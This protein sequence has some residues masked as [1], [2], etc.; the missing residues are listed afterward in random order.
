M[1]RLARLEYIEQTKKDKEYNDLV[2]AE[3]AEARY[4]KHYEI[5]YDVASAIIDFACK[6]A[7]YRELTNNLIPPTLWRHW[8]NPLIAGLP[9]YNKAEPAAIEDPK[10]RNLRE[11]EKAFASD[12]GFMT[13][14]QKQLL[15][16]CD[17]NE[18]KDLMGEWEMPE[19]IVVSKEKKEIGQSDN[20]VVG[21]IVNRLHN[22]CYPEQPGAPA[23]IFPQFPLKAIVLGKPFA[24]K[25]TAL[26]ALADG[27]IVKTSKILGS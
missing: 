16:E 27:K 1:T 11:I 25:T 24:G 26:K 17:F 15:D 5:C 14:E 2:A 12:T 19:Q 10:E 18:Y 3:K 6:E 8:R 7:E 13:E 21:H 4:K 9:L 23:P 20:K 22:I